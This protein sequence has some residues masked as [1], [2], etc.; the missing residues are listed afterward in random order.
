VGRLEIKAAIRALLAW[1]TGW[2]M[3]SRQPVRLDWR[4]LH[5]FSVTAD[6]KVSLDR[7]N[8]P[9]ASQSLAS[10]A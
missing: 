10:A 2:D 6:G 3:Q 9:M 5:Y 7:P 4:C 1:A 8:V